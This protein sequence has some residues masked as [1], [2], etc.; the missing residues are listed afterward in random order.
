ME[1]KLVFAGII[2]LLAGLFVGLSAGFL[3]CQKCREVNVYPNIYGLPLSEFWKII[4]EKTKAS[5]NSSLIWF[6]AETDDNGNLNHLILEFADSS[7]DLVYHVE[8]INGELSYY[9]AKAD[10][11]KSGGLNPV[12]LFRELEKLDFRNVLRKYPYRSFI[13]NAEMESGKVEYSSNS[14]GIYLLAGGSLIPLKKIV[15]CSK[16][17]WCR[18]TICK[19]KCVRKG[20]VIVSY[21]TGG[22]VVFLP[23]DLNKSVVVE[24]PVVLNATLY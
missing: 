10:G 6:Y 20:S 18:I 17:P 15:F 24:P 14:T 23:E 3:T 1:K 2:G 21:S 16:I 11:I 4:L 22:I 13:I 12:I 8:Y 5:R 19:M 9:T 7:S